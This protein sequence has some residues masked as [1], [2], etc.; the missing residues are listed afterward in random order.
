MFSS[1]YLPRLLTLI[2]VCVYV[3]LSSIY[4]QKKA[5]PVP[6]PDIK[7]G[8]VTSDHFNNQTTDSTAEAVVLYDFGQVQFSDGNND[9][10]MEFTHHVRIQIRKKSA[11]DR[12][13][14]ELGVRRGKAGQN[15]F[16]SNFEGCTYNIN[17][18]SV[19]FDKLDKS[20]HF[21]ERV[22]E[23]YSLEKYTLPNV[24]EGSIIEY[25]YTVR[26]PFN[27]SHNPRTWWFQQNIPVNWSEYRITVP[28]YFFYKIMQGGYLPLTINQHERSS[29]PLLSAHPEIGSTAYRFAVKDAPAFRD[30]SYI[31]TDDDYLSK[32][33]FELA[34]YQ[35]PGRATTDFS[36]TWEAL[37]RTLLMNASFGG[38]YKRAGFLRETAQSLLSRH[39]DTLG[40]VK[41]AYEFVKKHI[42]WSSESALWS[43]NVKKVFDDKKGDAADINL[44]LIALLREMDIEANPVILSTRSHG[45]I[46]EAYALLRKFNYVV[47]HV[48]LG[49]KDVLLDATDPYLQLGMLPTHCLNGSGRLVH[50]NKARFISLA[51]RERNV[52]AR[53]ATFTLDE[54][55]EVTGTL[56]HSHG[57]YS[58][59]SARKQ[60][61]TDGHTTYLDG[62]RK[63]RPSWQ[64][65][66]AKFE[67]VDSIGTFNATYALTI[68]EAC[69]RAGDRLYLRPMLSEAHGSN[70]FKEKERL[71]P[72]DF[73]V[74]IDENFLATYT[75]P[76]GF[77]VEELPKPVSMILPNNTGRFNYQ[78][79][80]IN[81]NQLQVVSRILLRKT[82]YFAEEYSALQ[83]FFSQ[84]VAKHAEQVVLKRGTVAEKK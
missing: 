52:E 42:K 1:R 28:D 11:Y 5:E 21:T 45:R 60:F 12:A 46:V 74:S 14:V 68:P 25:Q 17:G 84:I 66:Q 73:G 56:V 3:S 78:V 8:K 48:S 22:S 29:Y 65:E 40:R 15:E 24:R 57:G 47:A 64:I 50:A 18:G 82:Q 26:T 49:G 35:M 33:E 54:E 6:T 67:E 72:V 4:A 34:S 83:E 58:A 31:T 77:T 62:V 71:Y 20:G 76:A 75:L 55:G 9:F 7:F 37:D 36:V 27:V 53:N 30:E 63:K 13:T 2:V 19:A 10:W 16:V 41:G 39:K 61:A 81:R 59:W 44:L 70:P 38:Q 51:P 69:G 80:V 32:I 23:D 79:S 43:N